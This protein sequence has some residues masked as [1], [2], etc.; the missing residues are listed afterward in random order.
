MRP[1]ISRR[2][3]SVRLLA[4]TIVA[5]L[6]FVACGDDDDDAES[7]DT[8]AEATTTTAAEMDEAS[9]KAEITKN[10]ESFFDG[11]NKDYDAKAA[12]L[13]DGDKL[14][15]ILSTPDPATAEIA[16]KSGTKVQ[17]VELLDE[18]ACDMAG[19]VHPCA[20]VVHDL[21]DVTTNATL[22]PGQKS[23][24]VYV[25]GKWKLSKVTFCGLLSLGGRNPAECA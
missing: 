25:D 16:A 1:Y 24:A 15:T 18:T 22:L 6:V 9:A 10:F 17:S 21:I 4:L 23:Y 19:V 14:K 2:G 13:E 11:R 20:L 5:A 8:A 12:I 7:S 3:Q